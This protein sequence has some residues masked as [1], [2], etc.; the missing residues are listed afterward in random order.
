MAPLSSSCL[1]FSISAVAPPPP[2]AAAHLL[3]VLGAL[4]PGRRSMLALRHPGVLRDQV[5]ED[6]EERQK[7]REDPSSL[8]LP[9]PE[10]SSR[11]KMSPNDPEQQHEPCHPDEE[12]EHRPEDVEEGVVGSD[13]GVSSGSSSGAPPFGRRFLRVARS[14]ERHSIRARRVF[15]LTTPKRPSRTT[16]RDGRYPRSPLPSVDELGPALVPACGQR[17][18]HD[19]VQRH[20]GE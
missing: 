18:E 20:H 4:S 12:D 16:T 17:I 8:V 3:V 5:D 6:A 19:D 15:G 11:R 9:R 1:A 10:R 7:D 13:Q 2:A 14:T